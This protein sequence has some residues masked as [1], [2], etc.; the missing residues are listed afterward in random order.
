[1]RMKAMGFLL[2]GFFFLLAG[3]IQ[4]LEAAT[5]LKKLGRAP[6][7]KAK[8]LKA[9]Q[10]YPIATRLKKD[11]K[12]GFNQAGAADLFEPFMETLR[13]G[14]PEAVNIQ[15]GQS[16]QWMLYKKKGKVKV[17]K[18]RIWTGKTP[19]E[20]YR[21][22]VRHN[23]QNYDFII[24]K[25]CFNI[26][27]KDVTQV[28][29]PTVT[30]KPAETPKAVVPASPPPTP[31]EAPKVTPPVKE[32]EA[33]TPDTGVP[34]VAVPPPAPVP[35]KSKVEAQKGFFVGDVGMLARF[36]PSV[37]GLLRVGYRYKFAEP[38]ALT[39]LLGVAPLI[40]G[41]NDDPAFLADALFTYYPGKNFFM[42]AGVGLW[43]SSKDT[44]ADLILEIGIPI[45]QAP[46]HPSFEL[47]LEG[48]SAF[49]QMGDWTKYGR[50][51]WG[52]RILF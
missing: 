32:P 25:I 37:F 15:P 27:L 34:P 49:D 24:P 44:K 1:M 45:D 19:F 31:S 3:G 46:A 12:L 30:S 5:P 40:D 9:D 51:G 52:L 6:F 4:P 7:F 8:A 41:D 28:P 29:A 47:F 43:S 22:V 14:K 36:D 17:T 42:G 23:N 13:T 48:R 21:V 18:D 26:S 16:L 33:K 11:V 35:E 20:A 2:M 38:F 39:G 50:L 10:V